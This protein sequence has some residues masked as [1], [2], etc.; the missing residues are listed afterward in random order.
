MPPLNSSTVSHLLGLLRPRGYVKPA[1]P[2]HLEAVG[3]ARGFPVEDHF[4]AVRRNSAIA[5]EI[6]PV[7]LSRTADAVVVIVG[8]VQVLLVGGNKDAVGALYFVRQDSRNLTGGVDAV[9]TLNQL[10]GFILDLHGVHAAIA[11]ICEV[12]ASLRIDGEIIR[13]KFSFLPS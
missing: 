4:T 6:E 8:Y 9:H 11:R 10:A 5:P 1:F 13:R 12:D 3:P 2:V 7:E